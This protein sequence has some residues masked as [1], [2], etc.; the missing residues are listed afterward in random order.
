MSRKEDNE[1]K[2]TVKIISE[3]GDE[4]GEIKMTMKITKSPPRPK[5]NLRKLFKLKQNHEGKS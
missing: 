4:V 1:N 2:N 3:Q 5:V